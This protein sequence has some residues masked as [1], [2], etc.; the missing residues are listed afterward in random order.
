MYLQLNIDIHAKYSC[1]NPIL[2]VNVHVVT[3]LKLFC[4]KAYDNII[5][6]NAC[7]CMLLYLSRME[8]MYS[9]LLRHFRSGTGAQNDVC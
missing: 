7:P 5:I 3:P 2:C 6:S 1:R 4:F 8:F 9:D